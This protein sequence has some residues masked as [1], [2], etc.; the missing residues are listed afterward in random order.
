MHIR[1]S[2]NFLYMSVSTLSFS[3][4][5]NIILHI[6]KGETALAYPGVSSLSIL[7][8]LHGFLPVS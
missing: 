2:G 3:G 6:S 5:E 4:S 1:V 8:A 7:L